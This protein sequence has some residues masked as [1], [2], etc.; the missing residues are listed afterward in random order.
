MKKTFQ[1][2]FTLAEVL[3]TLGIIGVVAA[4]TLPAITA[5]YRKQEASART[6]KFY[7]TMLQ[8]IVMAENDFGPAKDWV[9]GQ[10][11]TETFMTYFAPYMKY[12]EIKNGTV[13]IVYFSDG[14]FFGL[15]DG[16]CLDFCFDVNGIKPPNKNGIDRLYFPLCISESDRKFWHGNPDQAFGTYEGRAKTRDEAITLCKNSPLYCSRLLQIDNWEFKSDY[17]Q[18]F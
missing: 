6:K 16:G 14:S 13:P 18:K 15:H 9:R 7:T 3:I 12:Q 4:M 5:S 10:N 17:P 11:A 2:G 8:A 1:I